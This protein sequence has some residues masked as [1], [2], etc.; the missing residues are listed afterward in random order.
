MPV[1]VPDPPEVVPV[2]VEVEDAEP[3]GVTPDVPEVEEA[4]PTP[5][6][7]PVPDDAVAEVDDLPEQ[8]VLD[9]VT[10][11]DVPDPTAALP[12]PVVVVPPAPVLVALTGGILIGTLADEH[13]DVTAF[14]TED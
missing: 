1:L 13:T 2:P 4:P 12:L 9:G 6:A 8:D 5:P 14:E 3:P 10:V 7:P 11:P